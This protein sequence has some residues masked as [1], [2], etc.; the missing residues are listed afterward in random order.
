MEY[1]MTYG[2]AILI[3][4]IVGAAL[5]ALGIFNP[6]TYTQSTATGF[7]NF[8]VPTG[9]WQLNSS[10]TLT[11]IVKNMAGSNIDITSVTADYAGSTQSNSTVVGGTFAPGSSKTIVIEGF[12]SPTAG[13]S[14]SVPVTIT[15]TNLDTGLPGFSSSGTVTGTVS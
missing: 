10:G 3:V 6:A 14:Y 4:I 2:W 12:T 7:T 13:S 9:G 8:Q 11:L 15:Y 5:Y 1:L